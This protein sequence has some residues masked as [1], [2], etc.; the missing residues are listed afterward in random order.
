MFRKSKIIIA[1]SGILIGF[2]SV[3]VV[4]FSLMTAGV[5][6]GDA[7][8]NSLVFTTGSMEKTYDGEALIFEKYSLKEGSLKEGHKFDVS[9]T[10]FQTEVGESYND[11]V[12]T[13]KDQS[14]YDVT[15]R[16]KI[17]Y[18]LGTLTV[19]AR[20]ITL[21][22]FSAQKQYDGVELKCHEY[23]VSAGSLISGHTIETNFT[24]SL[25]ERGKQENTFT[26]KI[27]DANNINVS[28]NYAITYKYGELSVTN[29]IVTI[30]SAS[31]E[32]VYDGT[33]LTCE[34]YQITEGKLINGHTLEIT[35]NGQIT[36]IGE[37]FNDF[38]ISVY[39]ENKNDVS[40][41]Y[42]FTKVKG[43]LKV[44]KRDI[45][46]TTGSNSF[47]YNGKDYTSE[48]FEITS[49]SLVNGHVF[50]P[51]YL[52][53]IKNAGKVD[54]KISYVIKDESD[55]DVTLNYNVT[56]INGEIE[57]LP[58]PITISSLS[59]T[60]YY[61][62]KELSKP[63]VNTEAV[64]LVEGHNIS[65][66]AIGKITNVGEVANTVIINIKD[67]NGD[68]V[69]NNYKVNLI[70]GKLEVLPKP[71]TLTSLSDSKYYD[72]TELSKTECT[73]DKD[74]LVN[75]HILTASAI[76]KII[77]VG[78]VENTIVVSIAD[79]F[80]V[81]VTKNYEINLLEGKLTILP[82]PITITTNGDSKIYDGTELKNEKYTI[83]SEQLLEG[84]VLD[85]K[86]ISSITEVGSIE[87][88]ADVVVKDEFGE[89]VTNNYQIN[90]IAGKLE[91]LPRSIVIS[92]G[93]STRY[94]DGTELKNEEYKIITSNLLEGHTMDIK[95]F[96][97][98]TN[99]GIES[100]RALVTIKNDKG[101]DV[102]LNYD[103]SV[104]EGTLEILPLPIT[105]TSGSASKIYDGEELTCNEYEVTGKYNV[106]DTH[107]LDVIITGSR[108]EPGENKNFISGAV[109]LDELL[110]NVTYNY[111]ISIILGTLT[112][113]HPDGSNAQ[114]GSGGSGGAGGAGGSGGA[115][116]NSEESNLSKAP[117]GEDKTEY[118]ELYSNVT[119]SVYLRSDSY[120]DYTYGGWGKAYNQIDFSSEYINPLYLSSYALLNNGLSESSI[121]IKMLVD[122]MT[123]HMP[124]YTTNGP[125]NANDY[126]IKSS[127]DNPYTLSFID[128]DF[129]ESNIIAHKNQTLIDLENRYYQYVQEHYLSLPASTKQAMQKIIEDNNINPSSSTL[130]SDVANYIQNAAVYNL[131]FKEFPANV[132]MA[133]YFLT[134][135]KEGICQHYATS[136]VVMY[137]TLGIPARYTT[138]F[139]GD[140]KA[141]QTTKVTG[142][143]AHAWVEVYI[144]TMGWV[145]V[146]V[147]GS[148]PNGGGANSGNG[149]G[150]GSG[151]GSGDKKDENKFVVKPIDIYKKYDGTT[152]YASQQVQG[153]S[154]LIEN[155]YTYDVEIIGENDSVGITNSIIKS[156]TIYDKD[157]NDVTS[158]FE[159][160]YKQG[161]IQNYINELE[162]YT[163]N[164]Q[165]EYDGS[166]M[167]STNWSY[168]GQLMEGHFIDETSISFTQTKSDVGEYL[169]IVSFD[170]YDNQGNNVTDSYY[171]K[172]NFGILKI[173]AKTVIITSSSATQ[174]YNGTVLKSPE[175][176]ISEDTP[177]V[178]GDVANVV[179][180]G[181]QKLPGKSE[182]KI[183]SVTIKNAKGE[184]V[185]KNY[186]IY[187]VNGTL[188]VT[189]K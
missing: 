34:E 116:G 61:D 165:K 80:G 138:G 86:M 74:A 141:N 69:T 137:R 63:E 149:S 157:L 147:T 19:H 120:G 48:S 13:I 46:I 183:S 103:V 124:Y 24:G 89:I 188:E 129:N 110:N 130:I 134:T 39:D 101:Y 158:K 37:K 126:I 33:P 27:Y 47:V 132:D 186:I 118:I 71:I 160:E 90:I 55:K 20:E 64:E 73:Y 115:G 185:T 119:T 173:Y 15:S 67:E 133:I 107:Q 114:G 59:E 78:E 72:G 159:I 41:Y 135:A 155:G 3:L 50:T 94:Y 156:F 87:N 42:E 4:Y 170:I 84:H 5:I 105:I 25:T 179:I 106:I 40:D 6:G 82:R 56:I 100:N 76:G 85:V 14:G 58:K 177:L 75:N 111:E 153:I 23:K 2:A 32:K 35:Y 178:S 17:T 43:I 148:G 95:T 83:A 38:N 53:K 108:T 11:I 28:K 31:S 154:T 184:D 121:T 125:V 99:A 21:E 169:N 164:S 102:S 131:K 29:Q 117:F 96:S 70:E 143:Q 91:V 166:S 145:P 162:V 140:T 9:F 68:D 10:G 171:I 18:D 181:Y 182:N 152:T 180:T 77:D 66:T 168:N 30:S 7:S 51:T 161:I 93:S 97:T 163:D 167:S 187:K 151:G 65:V 136:A 62:G 12:V 16:Y 52:S 109:V 176:T 22:S 92:T 104:V 81:D 26:G 1:I 112:V 146:E 36:D 175:Y 113:K 174:K 45:T 44:T 189:L 79:E 54:N 57:V 128:Y 142:Q 98:I 144:P 49:G 150:G 60:K 122:N 139:V 172:E 123:F 8:S 88:L 127:Y